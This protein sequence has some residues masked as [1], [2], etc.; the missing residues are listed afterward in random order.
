MGIHQGPRIKEILERL[1]EVK[2]NGKVSSKQDEEMLVK[3]W[4]AHD[5]KIC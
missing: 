4:L 1:H 3:D 5:S 2:L